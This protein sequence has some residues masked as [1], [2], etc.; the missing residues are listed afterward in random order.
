MNIVLWVL[1]ALL[2][3]HT[4]IGAVWK[5]SHS[6]AETM[7]SL[8]AIPN[9]IWQAMGAL[10]LLIAVALIAPA[11]SK[12]LAMSA[13]IAAIGIAVE[14]LLFT[15]LHVQSGNA[16]KGPIAYWLVVAILSGVIAYG[17]FALRAV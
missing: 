15:A 3:L 8:S 2:A 12:S 9:G 16:G 11:F 1:Q 6:A 10:E 13:P 4:A 7:P 5:F 14:M 17:R